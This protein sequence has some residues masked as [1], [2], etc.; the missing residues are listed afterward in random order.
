M[1]VPRGIVDNN[2]CVYYNIPPICTGIMCL[3]ACSFVIVIPLCNAN[4]LPWTVAIV[5]V[6]LLLS[7]MVITT[8]IIFGTSP[9]ET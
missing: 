8:A 9:P 3:C 7:A 1:I 2:A 6:V 4:E 5:L